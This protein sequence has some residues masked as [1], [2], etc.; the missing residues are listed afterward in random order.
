MDVFAGLD[1]LG[2]K[3]SKPTTPS[4]P[5]YGAPPPQ[6]NMGG[7]PSSNFGSNGRGVNNSNTMMGGMPTSN[8]GSNGGS[9][10]N[11][12]GMPGMHA[13]PSM[14]GMNMNM[15]MTMG[16]MPPTNFG[17]NGSSGMHMAG[18]MPGMH[19]MPPMGNM[20]MG[21]MNAMPGMMNMAPNGMGM[22]PQGPPGAQPVM[23]D[24]IKNLL[25][26]KAPPSTPTGGDGGGD[27]FSC[28]GGGDKPSS[29]TS[30][31]TSSNSQAPAGAFDPFGGSGAPP[32][33][34]SA[35]VNLSIFG[36]AAPSTSSGNISTSS[37]TPK[38]SALADRLRGSKRQTQE[39]QRASLNVGTYA[40][41]NAALAPTPSIKKQ[42]GGADAAPTGNAPATTATSS[43][44]NLLGF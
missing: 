39:A 13:M 34:A 17:S 30:S 26:K 1:P 15:G 42:L 25:E 40:N 9:S 7:M 2:G 33:P 35:G 41:S 8:Y 21:G 3:G 18:T 16:G 29:R 28:F 12:G 22:P 6:A 23:Y 20:N 5:P 14:G 31:G 38:N 27:M 43:P 36:D 37:S 24:N 10:I 19:A 32:A 11:M 4:Y 44:D